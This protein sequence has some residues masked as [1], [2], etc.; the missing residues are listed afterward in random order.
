MIHGICLTLV[1]PIEI[2]RNVEKTNVLSNDGRARLI[3]GPFKTTVQVS[4]RRSKLEHI[5]YA[6][7]SRLSCPRT[8][9]ETG[10]YVCIVVL[11]GERNVEQ[12]TYTSRTQLG[13]TNFILSIIHCPNL[14]K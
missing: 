12:I 9:V 5:L 4:G 7:F 2:I 8:G 14:V 13:I 1:S 10:D 11:C 3:T 6:L